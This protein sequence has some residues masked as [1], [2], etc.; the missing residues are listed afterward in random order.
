MFSERTNWSLS[1]NR[2]TQAVEEVRARGGKILDLSASNPTRIGLRYESAAILGALRSDKA[3][4]YDP[5]AKG[6]LSAREA[7]AGYYREQCTSVG[8]VASDNSRTQVPSNSAIN[9]ERIVLTASTSEGY[10]Y[11][12]R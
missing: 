11:V 7:V 8:D 3:L 2:F 6:L 4:D 10:S 5:Q 1:Q 9:P 12:F